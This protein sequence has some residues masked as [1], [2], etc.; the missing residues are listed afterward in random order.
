MKLPVNLKIISAVEC[1]WKGKMF[2]YNKDCQLS[3]IRVVG[4]SLIH[5]EEVARLNYRN[6]FLLHQNYKIRHAHR[7]RAASCFS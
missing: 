6:H 5:C 2:T 3:R 7:L 1:L 4:N